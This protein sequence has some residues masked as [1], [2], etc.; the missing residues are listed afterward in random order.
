MSAQQLQRTRFTKFSQNALKQTPKKSAIDP[1]F[2]PVFLFE[3]KNKGRRIGTTDITD[4]FLKKYDVIQV[5]VDDTKAAAAAATTEAAAAKTGYTEFAFLKFA[6]NDSQIN[7]APLTEIF[8]GGGHRNRED[9]DD[10]SARNKT[11][12]WLQSEDF[13]LPWKK[14]LQGY[15]LATF[16]AITANVFENLFTQTVRIAGG[17]VTSFRHGV[18]MLAGK[19]VAVLKPFLEGVPLDISL[20]TND[21]T[22]ANNTSL[23]GENI[24]ISSFRLTE[25]IARWHEYGADPGNL[26]TIL[27]D[28]ITAKS[29]NYQCTFLL[30]RKKTPPTEAQIEEIYSRWLVV[31][32]KN[33]DDIVLV[34]QKAECGENVVAASTVS[35][36]S[37]QTDTDFP[38]G[39]RK[40]TLLQSLW[41]DVLDAKERIH[42]K[43][44]YTLLCTDPNRPASFW[45]NL[46]WEQNHDVDGKKLASYTGMYKGKKIAEIKESNL[47]TL[48]WLVPKEHALKH[49][50]TVSTVTVTSDNIGA[51]SYSSL[52][53]KKNDFLQK[54]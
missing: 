45:I 14:T 53:D 31:Y 11:W 20:K 42:N 7:V 5:S 23:L 54:K 16:Q 47:S 18:A 34:R 8:D 52:Y 30:V 26:S 6:F 32:E 50:T 46:D 36:L 39:W 21:F 1:H 17:K 22:S 33:D 48:D 35:C 19:D 29:K 9:T 27:N 41:H 4:K 13:K 49:F 15:H 10:K 25:A 40:S 43:I 28:A 3:K 37:R 38:P 24:A 44:E 12:E 51:I 2:V